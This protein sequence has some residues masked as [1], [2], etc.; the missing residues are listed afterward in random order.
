MPCVL[1]W[2]QGQE[3]FFIF[4]NYFP[5]NISFSASAIKVHTTPL[6]KRKYTSNCCKLIRL[7]FLCSTLYDVPNRNNV[8]CH[9][10]NPYAVRTRKGRQPMAEVWDQM[11]WNLYLKT[12]GTGEIIKRQFI[13][14]DFF[15]LTIYL[16]WGAVR[17]MWST[18]TYTERTIIIYQN[19]RKKT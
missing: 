1:Y 9:V 4:K 19:K 6:P 17:R 14:N 3:H 11:A 7:F 8:E 13:I 12:R 5:L 18:K 15:V 2:C 16:M 10:T